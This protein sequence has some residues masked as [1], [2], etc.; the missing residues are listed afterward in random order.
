MANRETNFWSSNRLWLATGIAAGVF[1]GLKWI[2]RRWARRTSPVIQSG[3]SM[4]ALITGASSGIGR[5]YATKLAEMGYDVIVVARR[6]ERLEAL[7]TRL[8]QVYDVNA[9]VLTA[10][11][12]TYSGIEKVERVIERTQDLNLLVNNAGFGL[13]GQFSE[14]DVARQEDM[15]R[16]HVLAAVR[17]TRAALPGMLAQKRGAI[18]NVASVMAFYPLSGNVTYGATK[19][20]LRFFT[21]ALHQE[22][23][24]TGVRVQSLCP[25]FTRTEMQAAG[26]FDWS[27]LPDFVWLSADSVVDR[28]LRDLHNDR[29]I[30]VPGF[31][32][33]A[34]VFVRRLLPRPLLYLAGRLAGMLKERR[35]AER[36][37]QRTLA[38]QQGGGV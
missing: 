5:V 38:D 27:A 19:S 15:I 28:S 26:R 11:L 22:L 36:G 17:L 34:L 25:G 9:T 18:V 31:G 3:E 21:E 14:T 23:A 33:R 12:A 24:G 1:A 13:V 37:G 2:R 35:P 10:D 32:Y 6:V 20:Y 16:V 4:T 29:V 7:A 30:S 8:S